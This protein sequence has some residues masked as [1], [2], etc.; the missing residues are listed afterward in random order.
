MPGPDRSDVKAYASL[1]EYYADQEL[2][3]THSPFGTLGRL[4]AHE[5]E[6]RRALTDKLQLPARLFRDAR[7][8]E[9]GPD[10][11]ENA[12]VFAL[13]GAQC[14]LVEPNARAHATIREYFKRF[15]LA[16]RLDA[17]IESD[18]E[19]FAS[20]P[21]S[22][23]PYDMVVA[24]G[25]IYTVKP[26]SSWINLF[27]HLLADDGYALF[28]FYDP[29]S[30]LTELMLKVI[31]S[32]A[33]GWSG[34]PRAETARR[35]FAAKWDGIGHRRSI[36]SWI[37][38]V[39]DNP[40]VRLEYFIDAAALCRMM[41]DAGLTL[42]SAWPT[43]IDGLDVHWFKKAQTDADRLASQER[44]I[45]RSR[46]G[47][48]FGR[49]IFIVD[50]RLDVEERLT[51]L[52]RLVDGLITHFD[53]RHAARCEALLAELEPILRSGQVMATAADIDGA[54]ALARSYRT[55]LEMLARRDFTALVTFCN[56]DRAFIGDWGVPNHYAVFTKRGGPIPA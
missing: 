2:F 37:M 41:H 34:Q 14:T 53:E 45:A 31:H 12:L 16:D 18:I 33:C 24:E 1:P 20:T 47:H 32:T 30:C 50:D 56:S 43:Y 21:E 5:Y 40:F 19:R 3:P 51:E 25:F 55:M 48:L 4:M 8:I 42:Y 29:T 9:F 28:S 39:L 7:L 49:P 52:L 13:W 22:A 36:D 38:D 10:T 26:E 44:F 15:A 6:R 11:G 27:A 54:V 46:L 23:P 35:L 17:L